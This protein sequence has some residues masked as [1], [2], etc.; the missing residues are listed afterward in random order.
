[1][2]NEIDEMILLN[3]GKENNKQHLR[4]DQIQLD[5]LQTTEQQHRDNVG[6]LT[7]N[8]QSNQKLPIHKVKLVC[9]QPSHNIIKFKENQKQILSNIQDI[10]TTQT[11]P[12]ISKPTFTSSISVVSQE[13]T[14]IITKPHSIPIQ[15]Q[16]VPKST[17]EISIQTD[18]KLNECNSTQIPV[19]SVFE[20]ESVHL[21]EIIMLTILNS[22]F[23]DI[24]TST[25]F[26]YHTPK[27]IKDNELD[28][29]YQ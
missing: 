25:Q 9:E 11:N 1:M 21:S 19:R 2:N 20:D 22:D 14:S 6:F 29:Q 5:T 16:T 7:E 18:D 13:S 15:S 12:F 28:Q 8:T 23:E 4:Q 26:N 3:E 27:N 17:Q 10:I 24:N